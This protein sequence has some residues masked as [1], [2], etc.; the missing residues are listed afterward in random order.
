MD[1]E[2]SGGKHKS[3][4]P[5]FYTVFGL[6]IRSEIILSEL[7][8]AEEDPVVFIRM[9]SEDFANPEMKHLPCHGE[10]TSEEAI[11]SFKEVGSFRIRGGTDIDIW[12]EPCA[13]NR[14]LRMFLHGV[15]SAILL[16]QRGLLVLHGSCMAVRHR[17]VGFLG[18]SGSGKSTMAAVLHHRGHDILSEDIV[19]ID[20][21]YGRPVT[22]P[23]IPQLK[24][25]AD[26]ITGLGYPEECMESLYPLS[27]E[28]LYRYNRK[29]SS[30]ECIHMRCIFV[31]TDADRINIRPLSPR[32]GFMALM[33][34]SYTATVIERTQGQASHFSQ[35]SR[36]IETI[37]V[38][39]L[40][41][42]RDMGMLPDVARR[43]EAFVM[44]LPERRNEP[45]R[46]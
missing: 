24:L 36:L 2:N 14:L 30:S 18:P 13:D 31:I 22:Y 23:G 8:R 21:G 20:S 19:P 10:Y 41:R 46:F 16:H 6:R 3:R 44:D 26:I 37:P 28:F 29:L 5:N 35:C 43:V 9:S 25:T 39:L 34:N 33:R 11:V 4:Q 7:A 27:N 38:C 40:E 45:S 1:V 12:K 42:P 32:D 15:V 17:A